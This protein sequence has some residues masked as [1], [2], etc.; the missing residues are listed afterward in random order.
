MSIRSAPSKG[1][2]DHSMEK[3]ERAHSERGEQ[4]L[5]LLLQLAIVW[6][7]SIELH[8]SKRIGLKGMALLLKEL[9][10]MIHV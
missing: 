7:T 5:G 2:H 8:H 3:L 6:S 4:G 10:I 1:G 9:I